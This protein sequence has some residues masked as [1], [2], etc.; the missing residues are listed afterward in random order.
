MTYHHHNLHVK[1]RRRLYLCSK[2]TSDETV[3][4]DATWSFNVLRYA[5]MLNNHQTSSG[6]TSRCQPGIAN[7]H[8]EHFDPFFFENLI[9]A[10][11]FQIA[12]QSTATRFY[13]FDSSHIQTGLPLFGFCSILNAHVQVFSVQFLSFAFCLCNVHGNQLPAENTTIC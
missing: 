1:D 11:T 12:E 5:S 9:H 8:P 3:S 7:P 6:R 4:E 10:F 13:L 2:R